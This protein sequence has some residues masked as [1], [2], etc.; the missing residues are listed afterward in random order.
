MGGLV[1]SCEVNMKARRQIDLMRRYVKVVEGR[2]GL[3]VI[4]RLEVIG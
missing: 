4:L 3:K 2:G 1:I